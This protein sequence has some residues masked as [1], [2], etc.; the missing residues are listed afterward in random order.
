MLPVLFLL[1]AVQDPPATELAWKWRQG[2]RV[3]YEIERRIRIDR[4]AKADKAEGRILLGVVLEVEEAGGRGA[5]KVKITLDRTAA[6]GGD[7][8]PKV[9]YDS[10][11]DREVSEHHYVRKLANLVGKSFSIRMDGTGAWSD[12]GEFEKLV[13]RAME[14]E[15]G[16]FTAKELETEVRRISVPLQN[17]M[18]Q[19]L[20]VMPSK[21]VKRGEPWEN[22]I[23]RFDL[24][25]AQGSFVGTSTLKEMR[26]RE[27]VIVQSLGCDFPDKAGPAGVVKGS[28]EVLWDPDRGRLV[29]MNS[30]LTLTTGAETV[31]VTLDAKLSPRKDP[32]G[33]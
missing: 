1:L 27:A 5:A 20:G 3:R 12:A 17:L 21:S 24:S 26:G 10:D 30:N 14:L 29:S 16:R 15:P 19:A 6:S 13:L 23:G 31:E 8:V 18:E 7:S 4:P 2:E 25:A 28:G 32:S 22:R 33:K 11:R 9:D